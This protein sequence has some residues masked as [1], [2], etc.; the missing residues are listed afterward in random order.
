MSAA[1]GTQ[2]N[3]LI[4]GPILPTLLRLAVPNFAAMFVSTLV[5]IA[6]TAYIGQ[7]GTTALA[8]FALVFP[9]AMLMQMMSAGA[10]GGG[11]SSAVSRALG[12]GDTERA[13]ALAM[14]AVIIGALAAL[15]FTVIFALFG[16]SIVAA[17]GGRGDT[18]EQGFAY[19]Q[20]L[21]LGVA[22]VWVTNT[23]ASIL[24]GTGNMKTPSA[25]LLCVSALQIVLGFMLGLGFGPIP[26]L[27]MAGV[28][29]AL[30][31]SYGS[32]A[33]V[34]LWL[35]MTGRSA[36]R[37]TFDRSSL[38]A[39]MFRDIL[40]VGAVA[41]ASP[42]MSVGTVLIL[43]AIVARFGTEALA[44]YGIG[45]RLEFMLVPITFAFGVASIPMVGMAI[46]SGNPVRAKRAAWTAGILSGALMGAIGLVVAVVPDAWGRLY[47]SNAKVLATA[48]DYFAAA[49]PA[50]ALYGLGLCLYFASQGSGKMIGPVLVAA[51]RL[52]IVAI[53]GWWLVYQ[54]APV[55]HLF[56]VIGLSLAA[57]GIAMALVVKRSRWGTA[58]GHQTFET[59]ERPATL[60]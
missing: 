7:L 36:V 12:A 50:Y 27:G 33:T 44:G 40:K 25:V 56:V 10:M 26:G 29:L 6:E 37:L 60:S 17:L 48:H 15:A 20:V 9:L 45:A 5:V 47:S 21:F 18:A 34:L 43:T 55:A 49:G 3:A 41:C 35:L 28:A 16:R 19:A 24:R 57:Y 4:D 2:H 1:S 38:S 54:G 39:E 52:L 32:G 58:K 14:H 31:L 42:L 51:V 23:C 59:Q 46:G 11:V 30:V 13:S 53:G 22:S 8:G